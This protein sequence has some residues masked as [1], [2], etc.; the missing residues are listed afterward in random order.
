MRKIPLGVSF[1]FLLI[2]SVVLIGCSQFRHSQG[3]IC[4]NMRDDPRSLDPREVR[5]L[6]NINLIRHIYEGLVQENTHTGEIEPALAEHYFISED[7][8]QYTFQ[9]R[10]AYWSNGDPLTATDFIDSWKQVVTHEVGGVY[11]FAFDPIKNAKKVSQQNCSLSEV[12]FYAKDERTL[13]IDLE[14]PT[15]H[16]LKLLSLPIFF[17]V[18][19]KQREGI[20]TKP[21]TNGA[22]YPKKMKAKQWIHLEKNPYYYNQ[23][24][25]NT[26]SII[27]H[28]IPDANTAALLFNQGKLHWQGPPWGERIPT[29]ALAYLQSQGHLHTFE[30][31]GTSWIT[32]NINKFPFNHAKLRKAMSL[33]LDKE[34]LVA[35]AFLDRVQPASHL[36]PT[37]IHKYPPSD[38]LS[39]EHNKC[40]AKKLFVEAMKEL[41]MSIKDI[42]NHALVFPSSSASHALLVQLVREQWKETLGFT[43]PI[44]GKEFSLL[45]K[46]LT[47]GQFSLA[48]GEWFADFSDPMAFLSIFGTSGVL[49]YR[50]PHKDFLSLLATIEHEREPQRRLELISQAAL[51]LESLHIIEPIYHDAFHVALN[52]KFSNLTLSPTGIVD[53]R[54]TNAP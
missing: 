1:G 13:V 11:H 38:L 39:K 32:F 44:L 29:E 40:L 30:V 19:K 28:F 2:A 42:E 46:E 21:I 49:P 22:F 25:V 12:G 20:T 51:Y 50:I 43:I 18:H 24:Q 37:N 33:A 5:L 52:K 15:S 8:M 48:T 17:P 36:L 6:S 53:F 23:E 54:H 35:A 10:Q 41:G 45:Q 7:G 3:Q 16:F 9:L 27:V 47:S 4:I 14:S 26:H 31:A 34:A